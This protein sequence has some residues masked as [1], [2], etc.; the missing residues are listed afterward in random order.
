MPKKKVKVEITDTTSIDLSL[1]EHDNRIAD[2]AVDIKD[3]Y[4]IIDKLKIHV[5]KLRNRLGI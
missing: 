2:N 4:E 3:I 5:D 1:I